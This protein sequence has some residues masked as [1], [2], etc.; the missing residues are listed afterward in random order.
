MALSRRMILLGAT[1]SLASCV[2]TPRTLS[3]AQAVSAKGLEA[4][5]KFDA[6]LSVLQGSPDRFNQLSCSHNILSH[7]ET[8]NRLSA[9]SREELC[10]IEQS[11]REKQ[12]AYREGVSRLQTAMAAFRVAYSAYGDLANI[13]AEQQVTN[14]SEQVVTSLQA[15]LAAVGKD[16]LPQTMT[17]RITAATGL[18]ASLAAEAHAR[19]LRALNDAYAETLSRVSTWWSGDMRPVLDSVREDFTLFSVGS[20]PLACI[21]PVAQSEALPFPNEIVRRAMRR[22]QMVAAEVTAQNGV[23]EQFRAVG[24][25]LAALSRAHRALAQDRPSAAEAIAQMTAGINRLNAVLG[26]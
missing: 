10:G 11:T 8:P 15:A 17:S 2:S 20:T 1:A 14:A 9:Q 26:G 5:S 22:E 19:R 23:D 16:A 18:L 7:C 3:L 6:V 25:A 12:S 13:N 21:A 4:A 24:A